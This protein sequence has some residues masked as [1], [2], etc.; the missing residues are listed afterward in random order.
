MGLSAYADK[1]D[2]GVLLLIEHGLTIDAIRLVRV[3]YD[4][5]LLQAKHH[6]EALMAERS[7]ASRAYAIGE[8][9]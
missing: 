2:R 6:V 7:N 1:T 4:L 3:K 5:P 9:P 8:A